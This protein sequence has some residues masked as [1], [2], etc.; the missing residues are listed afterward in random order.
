MKKTSLHKREAMALCNRH[1]FFAQHAPKFR[2][3]GTAACARAQMRADFRNGAQAVVC[4][5]IADGRIPHRKTRA[6]NRPEGGLLLTR[7][8]ERQDFRETVLIYSLAEPGG[9]FFA[10]D[11]QAVGIFG[12]KKTRLQNA[13]DSDGKAVDPSALVVNLGP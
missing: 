10:V 3:T 6:D 1:G 9:N 5:G 12:K 11:R 2:L 13:R 4:D 7:D 8:G